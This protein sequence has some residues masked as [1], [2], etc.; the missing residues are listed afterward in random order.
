MKNVFNLFTI[1]ILTIVTLTLVCLPAS[2]AGFGTQTTPSF[3]SELTE[4]S[5]SET[6]PFIDSF[7]EFYEEQ[8]QNYEEM[9]NEAKEEQKKHKK[10][11][12]DVK[13]KIDAS[14]VVLVV[15]IVLSLLF[16]IAEITYILISAP[17][18]GMSRLWALVPLFSSIFG[19]IVFI[20]VRSAK[21]TTTSTHTITCPVCNGV[22]PVGTTKCSICGANL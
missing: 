10:A 11:Y 14:Q 3:S 20:V 6:N 9:F 2:A 8:Q 21:V 15:I 18:C 1:L 13:E 19:L 7:K 4:I 22:H 16:L 5:S 12:K 17:K